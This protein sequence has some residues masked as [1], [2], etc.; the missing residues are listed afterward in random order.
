MRSKRM[1]KK[2]ASLALFIAIFLSACGGSNTR[3]TSSSPSSQ[4]IFSTCVLKTYVSTYPN[5]YLGSLP[6]P[7]PT[8][9]FDTTLNRMV[10]LK[11]YL[12]NCNA[13]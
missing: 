2:T 1:L 12:L 4:P 13:K 6:I 3:E 9:Q 5:S 7:V 8:Q 10:G 11:D